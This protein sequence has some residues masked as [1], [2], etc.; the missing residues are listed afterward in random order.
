MPGQQ[1]SEVDRRK[2][3]SKF[4]CSKCELL[5]N[6][7]MQTQC[8]H[9]L[10]KSCLQVIL[11]HANPVCP[12]DGTSLN[13]N[14]IFLDAF[15]KRE[16]A[17][18]QLHCLNSEDCDWFGAGK[19]LQAHINICDHT[20]IICVHTQCPTKVKRY[21]L[22]KHLEEQCLY[23]SVK[24]ENCQETLP[25]ASIEIF[26]DAFTKRELAALKL[27]CLNSEDCDW[28]GAGKDLQ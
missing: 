13:E 11:S 22:A 12:K 20:V 8:G 4:L 16:L 27:H 10:C 23:R 1:I 6:E 17:A 25:F 3:D 18:L 15:T 2:I 21:L 19:D 28:F 24:C 14:S 7:P 9:L 26:L 5:L